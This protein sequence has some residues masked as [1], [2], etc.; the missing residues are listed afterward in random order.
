M[1]DQFATTTTTTTLANIVKTAYDQEVGFAL[2][3]QPLYRALVTKRPSQPAMP[4]SA[5]V[6]SL[7]ADIAG[8]TTALTEGADISSTAM[9]APTQVTVTPLEYGDVVTRTKVV[10]LEAF[11]QVDPGIA[12]VVAYSMA[13]AMDKLVAAKVITGTNVITSNAGGI[14]S[15]AQA[16]NTL[17]AADI[18]SSTHV[19]YCVSKLRGANAIPLRGQLYGCTLHP[20]TSFDLRSETGGAGW[21]PFHQYTGTDQVWNGEIGTYQGAFFIESSRSY[22]ATDGASS[23]KVNRTLF[24]GQEAL[25]EAVVDEP[26]VVIGPPLDKLGRYAH[27]GWNGIVGWNIYRQAALYRVEHGTTY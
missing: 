24:W 15:T 26:H 18:F 8:N 10:D 25:A 21:V 9:G 17:T 20:D 4:G 23:A 16:T 27:L 13:D 5:I 12:N 1:A 19:R 14:D 6:L 22:N 11:T 2:R 7:W 3:A